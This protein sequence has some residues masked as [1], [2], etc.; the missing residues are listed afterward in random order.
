MAK[1]AI[2]IG[3]TGLTGGLLV[4]Q[5]LSDERYD[6]IK[7]ISRRTTGLTDTKIEEKL[8]HLLEYDTWKDEIKGDHLFC[9]IGTTRKKTP[10]LEEYKKIDL[11]IPLHA[12]QFGKRNGVKTFSVISAIGANSSSSIFYNKLK[13]EMEEAVLSEG[14]DR[15]Y[16]MRPSIIDGQR[17][18]KR[19]MELIGLG[20]FRLLGFLFI[21][22]LRKY[23]MIHARDIALAMIIAANS[24]KASTVFESD[25]IVELVRNA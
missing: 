12:A 2:V 10:D 14:P 23:R 6:K 18:E 25:E 8:C 5:L 13:G 9:C 20:L 24:V 22:K 16:V 7:I 19:L 11:G 17:G 3:A 4:K 1:T 15:V 21:G